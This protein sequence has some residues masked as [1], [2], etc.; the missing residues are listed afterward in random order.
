MTSQSE[1]QLIRTSCMLM[2]NVTT[3]L[4]KRAS[5]S[6]QVK[7]FSTYLGNG[8]AQWLSSR[9]TFMMALSL[10]SMLK[11]SLCILFFLSS[12]RWFFLSLRATCGRAAGARSS[13]AGKADRTSLAKVQVILIQFLSEI[14]ANYL[15]PYFQTMV[16]ESSVLPRLD[17]QLIT[18][19]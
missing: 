10:C 7:V 18:P 19:R 4:I 9:L 11:L 13:I 14:S 15:K 5:N 8:L 1:E 3:L 16:F 17:Q 6:L 12:S 2:A